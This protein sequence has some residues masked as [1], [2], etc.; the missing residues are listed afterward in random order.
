MSL[1]PT[2]P[3]QHIVNRLRGALADSAQFSDDQLVAFINDGYQAAAERSRCIRTTVTVPLVVAQQEYALP[4]DWV[5]TLG[6]YV[7]GQRWTPLSTRIVPRRDSGNYY[8][9]FGSILGLVTTPNLAGSLLLYYA[10]EPT[11]LA[12]TDTPDPQFPPERYYILRHY[13][14]WQCYLNGYGAEAL[15]RAMAQRT[16]WEV[17]VAQLERWASSQDKVQSAGRIQTNVSASRPAYWVFPNAAI[18]AG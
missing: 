9:S 4:D 8:Y 18:N 3:I 14:A 6:V 5:S 1:T 15:P 13:A 16:A 7:G 10:Q 11:P 12:I 2:A 17:G